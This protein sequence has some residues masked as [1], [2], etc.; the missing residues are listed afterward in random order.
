MPTGASSYADTLICAST[1]SVP[2]PTGASSCAG[3]LYFAGARQ[4]PTSPSV[5]HHGGIWCIP[6]VELCLD[7]A[8]Q[9]GKSLSGELTTGPSSVASWLLL[10][11]SSIHFDND[12]DSSVILAF[13]I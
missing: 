1:E 10:N 8:A 4:E 9:A 13:G 12:T 11:G 5:F 3:A 7:A 2:V 6:E